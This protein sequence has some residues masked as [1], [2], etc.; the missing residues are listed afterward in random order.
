MQPSQTG[1]SLLL[2]YFST[3]IGKWHLHDAESALRTASLNTSSMRPSFCEA[4]P[5]LKDCDDTIK[6]Y[7]RELFTRTKL[8][9]GSIKM[10]EQIQVSVLCLYKVSIYPL[11]TN[12][13]YTR[14]SFV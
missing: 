1:L 2:F 7:F 8:D 9:R 13:M 6:I 12:N 4:C 10:F 3:L 14:R 5:Q 11:L